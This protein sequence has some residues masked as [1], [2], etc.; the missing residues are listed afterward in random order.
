MSQIVPSDEAKKNQV[1]FGFRKLFEIVKDT[2]TW[3]LISEIV[4]NWMLR[5]RELLIANRRIK[6]W[7]LEG[8]A[9]LPV[10]KRPVLELLGYLS[11]PDYVAPPGEDEEV[12]LNQVDF[13]GL[14]EKAA[15]RNT[16][17]SIE[18]VLCAHRRLLITAQG[19]IGNVHPQA[20][21]GDLICLVQGCSMPVVFRRKGNAHEVI[22]DAWISGFV[23]GSL[24]FENAMREID[25]G[26]G[27]FIHI[28]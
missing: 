1:T 23:D 28:C 5:D 20:R 25:E 17:E 24:G 18:S 4:L 6:D 11:G 10:T 16:I 22:G 3:P 19:F 2:G 13:H 27:G 7:S 26:K 15:V 21:E 12:D 8:S 9:A 14:E